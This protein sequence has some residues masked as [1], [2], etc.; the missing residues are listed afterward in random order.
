VRTRS[1]SPLRTNASQASP[2]VLGLVGSTPILHKW[3]RFPFFKRL[4]QLHYRLSGLFVASAYAV[5]NESAKTPETVRYIRL[6]VRINVTL[7]PPASDFVLSKL[8]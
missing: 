5:A 1:S 8:T 6:C 7:C 4:D 3:L 2:I